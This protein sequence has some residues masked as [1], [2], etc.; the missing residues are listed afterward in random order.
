MDVETIRA[1][2]SALPISEIQY[3]P[4]TYSTNDDAMAWAQAGAPEGVVVIADKQLKGRGRL[5]RM[6]VTQPGTSLAFSMIFRP[7]LEEIE[8]L[9]LFS[10]LGALAVAVA[11]EDLG[12]SPEI[13]WPNDV[14]LSRKKVCGVLAET[15]WMGSHIN[16]VVLGIGI[17]VA[18]GS[19]PDSNVLLFPA[20]CVESELGK[21]V[22]RLLL[23]ESV[24]RHLIEWRKQIR[25]ER[26]IEEWKKRL[27]FLG[28]KVT[29][30]KPDG[31]ITGWF[32]DVDEHGALVL[33]VEEQYHTILAGDVKLR[34]LEE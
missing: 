18:T 3:L 29:V 32:Q 10:P 25:T 11:L 14:L 9:S 34:P 28:E 13:K 33:S 22:D 12:L 27:A 8:K 19:V 1:R 20:T 30:Q 4:E 15:V 5:G 2:L 6:W 17:N 24:L 31:E 16:G 23:L 21:P 26:F 7:T